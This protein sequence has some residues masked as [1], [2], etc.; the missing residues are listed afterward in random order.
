MIFF[1]L[2]F[3]QFRYEIPRW[4]FWYL[5]CLVLH[6]ISHWVWKI[7]HHYSSSISFPP[8]FLLHLAFQEWVGYSFWICPT[9]LDDS[10]LVFLFCFFPLILFYCW[11]SVLEAFQLITCPHWNWKSFSIHV[12]PLHFMV[13]N[14]VDPSRE[15]LVCVEILGVWSPLGS[16]N[17]NPNRIPTGY[18]QS[19]NKLTSTGWASC[20]GLF[21]NMS[22]LYK[23]V[24]SITENAVND[25]E[26]G[27]IGRKYFGSN[28][29]PGIGNMFEKR[30]C[31]LSDQ[32]L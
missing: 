8:F 14:S 11:I 24:A 29:L 31:L 12:S 26:D 25:R 6:G 23:N 2:D 13:P 21:K 22:L 32:T 5:S 17:K 18:D 3:L 10:L 9:N 7:L 19:Q 16:T 28:C 20:H 15:R 30:D 27:G 4:S 1:V